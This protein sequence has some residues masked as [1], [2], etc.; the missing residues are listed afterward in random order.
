MQAREP[1]A[2]VALILG[3]FS[4]ADFG[5]LFVPEVAGVIVGVLALR[6]IAGSAGKLGRG[7]AWSGIAV[8]AISLIVALSVYCGAFKLHR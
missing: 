2:I 1:L 5:V 4:L 3:V 8:S 7:L 6:R